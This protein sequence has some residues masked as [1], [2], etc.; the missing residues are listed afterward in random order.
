MLF[1][2]IEVERF[3]CV[4]PWPTTGP[5]ICFVGRHEP[6]KGLEVLLEALTLLPP[7]VQLWVAGDGA[8]TRELHEAT[9][10][11][12]RVI[13]LG[14]VNDAG[15]ARRLRGA[16][17]FCAPSLGG[18]S[19]G[20]VLLEAMAAGVPVVA[21][22]LTGYRAVA[23]S[24]VDALLVPPGDAAAL[25]EALGQHAYGCG[26]CAPPGGQRVGARDR[27]R[28]GAPGRRV[29]GA[30]PAAAVT[31]VAAGTLVTPCRR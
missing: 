29:P 3:A 20:V 8:Q 5:T 14:R 27:V 7:A 13:W 24:G 31:S 9:A 21:S 17:V 1:N 15:K 22:D 11:D 26:P 6:R 18:E 12:P 2:G 19:F 28:D 4:E 23:R 30:L 16:D 10:G 25:A